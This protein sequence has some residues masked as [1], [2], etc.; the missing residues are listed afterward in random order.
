MK[1]KDIF[2]SN[3][4]FSDCR[5]I[6]VL[7]DKKHPNVKYIAKNP[8]ERLV[9]VFYVDGGLISDNEAKCDKLLVA[10]NKD[11]K[12]HPD[13]YFVE[14][15]GADFKTAIR[16]LNRSIDV[17]MCHIDYRSVNCRLVMSRCP[18]IKSS[19]GIRLERKLKSLNGNFIRQSR[20]LEE[21]IKQQKEK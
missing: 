16:Q 15:K 10:E 21:T 19:N 8:N 6:V 18:D 1:Y 7:A 12:Q 9:C 11:E 17:L 4:D 14:L 5:K 3:I 2:T 20:Q 13:F